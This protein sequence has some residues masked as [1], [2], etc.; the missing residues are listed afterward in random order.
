MR[1]FLMLCLSCLF[2]QNPV[3]GATRNV[4][5]NFYSDESTV[6]LAVTAITA[7]IT[8][9]NL[10]A[11]ESVTITIEN[12]GNVAQA[13]I[14]VRFNVNSGNYVYETC[15][16]PIPAGGA[17]SYTFSTVIDLSVNG[18]YFICAQTM[19][20]NDAVSSNDQLCKTI[21]KLSCTPFSDQCDLEGIKQLQ[22]G[23]INV[24]DG[25]V[26]CNT[27]LDPAIKG[28]A[29]RTNLSTTLSRVSEYNTHELKVQTNAQVASSNTLS[30]WIDF[31]D[32]K[33]FETTEK[34]I[35]NVAFSITGAL[36]TFNFTI[37]VTAALGKHRMR[38]RAGVSSSA[39]VNN[40]CA[41]GLKGE[42]QDYLVEV[43]DVLSVGDDEHLSETITI[44]YL[45][46]NQ[47]RIAFTENIKA[48]KRVAVFNLLGQLIKDAH[49]KVDEKTYVLDLSNF[50]TGMYLIQFLINGKMMTKRVVV[51]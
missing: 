14:P 12:F 29:D 5:P 36:E 31:N 28:Y 1:L 42:T 34:L 9:A 30:M 33:V 48:T 4:I 38:V 32:D 8:G 11:Y 43:V 44:N 3:L 10:G 21:T 2:L 35:D 26:G 37:P 40:P 25:G 16:G 7:P 50:K 23:T 49:L 22:L 27:E 18:D 47:Y 13:N 45:S 41:N 46:G 19:M 24:D 20:Q 17:V 6:D 15:P 39:A 51:K